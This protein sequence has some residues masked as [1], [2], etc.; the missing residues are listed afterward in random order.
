MKWNLDILLAA[1]AIVCVIILATMAGCGVEQVDLE[2]KAEVL[3]QAPAECIAGIPEGERNATVIWWWCAFDLCEIVWPD[4][5]PDPDMPDG[6][7]VTTSSWRV[8]GW[9]CCGQQHC[10][11]TFTN[12]GGV[13]VFESQEAG[14]CEW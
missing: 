13:W 1:I 9:T 6:Y 12:N 10:T 7:V 14:A 4:V 3:N 8:C 5:P 11:N 2:R